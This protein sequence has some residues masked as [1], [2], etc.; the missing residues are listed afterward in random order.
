MTAPAAAAEPDLVALLTLSDQGGDR[1]VA[2]AA[3]GSTDRLFGGQ[4]A[5]QAL[6]AATSTLPADRM[7]FVVHAQ[8]LRPGRPGGAIELRVTRTSDSPSVATRQVVAV[9][10]GAAILTATVG[11]HTPEPGL[12]RAEPIEVGRHPDLLPPADPPYVSAAA[13]RFEWRAAEVGADYGPAPMWLRIRPGSASSCGGAALAESVL[14]FASDLGLARRAR[15]EHPR[16]D[17]WFS[18]TLDHSVWFHRRPTAADDWYLM[19]VRPTV[20]AHGRWL[21]HA[22]FHSVDGVHIASVSQ[23]A[24]I[25]PRRAGGVPGRG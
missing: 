7:P 22:S 6:R 8:F 19:S 23:I 15:C 13:G 17:E 11:Y 18:A 5:A 16:P 20:A 14:T 24:L 12:D 2:A 4:V 21:V 9:Q 1:F 10:E 25:R 3:A